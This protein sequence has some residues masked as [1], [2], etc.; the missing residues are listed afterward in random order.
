MRR[1]VTIKFIG[2]GQYQCG[3]KNNK[4]SVS[5]VFLLEEKMLWKLKMR[6]FDD[7]CKNSC[8]AYNYCFSYDDANYEKALLKEFSTTC[9]EKNSV[10][11]YLP[12]ELL[13]ERRF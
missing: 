5:W 6:N 3:N 10:F 7:T 1:T 4:P 8:A 9:K 2:H 13:K 11:E 12:V